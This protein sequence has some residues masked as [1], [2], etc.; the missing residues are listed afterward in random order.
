MC[1]GLTDLLCDTTSHMHFAASSV[2]A[3]PETTL[4]ESMWTWT[5]G[6]KYVHKSVLTPERLGAH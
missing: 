1:V 5:W 3:Q 2:F 6:T 4:I